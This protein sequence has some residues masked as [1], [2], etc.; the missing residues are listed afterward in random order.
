MDDR[1][2]MSLSESDEQTV[3]VLAVLEQEFSII[4]KNEQYAFQNWYLSQLNS[5]DGCRA[6][7]K[8]QYEA[9]K[10]EL[11]TRQ[12]A[13]EYRWYDD[14]RTAVEADLALPEN[15][16]KKSLNYL[17][18]KAGTRKGKDK[19]V[20]TDE[21]KAVNWALENDCGEAVDM[22]LARTSSLM[23]SYKATKAAPDGCEIVPATTSFFP[24]RVQ[25]A[26]AMEDKPKEL[27]SNEE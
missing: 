24:K 8:A 18:G 20:V 14:F 19:L 6:M 3:D 22:K 25:P 23:G 13:L 9:M 16:K 17:Q 5:L 12:R 4:D 1:A 26:L 15:S 10:R 2:I 11:D 21:A 7:L 27:E